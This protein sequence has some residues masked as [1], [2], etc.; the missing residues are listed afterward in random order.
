MVVKLD[1]IQTL[2]VAV[3]VL[4]M[5]SFVKNISNTGEAMHTGSGSRGLFSILTL[6][7][8]SSGPK[9]VCPELDTTC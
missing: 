3:M 5:G 7:G 6:L 1:I 4:F 2:A 8:Y 9:P